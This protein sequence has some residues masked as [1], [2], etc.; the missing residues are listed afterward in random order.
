MH[1]HLRKL[2]WHRSVA[3]LLIGLVTS[4]CALRVVTDSLLDEQA[5]GRLT[6]QSL[7][8]L[9]RWQGPDLA[10]ALVGV[11][12]GVMHQLLLSIWIAPLVVGLWVLDRRVAPNL[13]GPGALRSWGIQALKTSL[14]LL[15]LSGAVLLLGLWR[16]PGPWVSTAVLLGIAQVFEMGLAWS[17]A[18]AIALFGKRWLTFLVTA[19]G[20][21]FGRVWG[22]QLDLGKLLSTKGSEGAVA[23]VAMLACVLVLWGAIALASRRW[24]PRIDSSVEA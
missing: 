15:A 23:P 9:V 4:A 5:R 17:V 21:G 22:L 18:A 19:F 13:A 3:W 10:S 1:A 7:G 16:S 8:A 20:L 14:A 6:R 2:S 12:I 24:S 11:P